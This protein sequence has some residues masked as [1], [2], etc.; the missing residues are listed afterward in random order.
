[1]LEGGGLK[2]GVPMKLFQFEFKSVEEI[3]PWGSGEERSLS[4][5]ALTDGF[6]RMPVG[7]QVLFRYRDEILAHLGIAE[8]DADY[9]IAAFARDI[10]GALDAG[11]APLSPRMEEL[12]LN[13]Q[14]LAVLEKAGKNEEF[15]DEDTTYTAWRWLGERSPWTS[16]LSEQPNFSFIR[17]KDNVHIRWDNRDK[18]IDGITVWS[19]DYGELIMPAGEFS[20]ECNSFKDRLLDAM[21][22][23]IEAIENGSA[24]PQIPVDIDSL[25]QQLVN[26]QTEFESYSSYKPDFAWD[27]VEQA[28]AIIAAKVGIPF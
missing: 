27:E 20:A 26:W 3:V 1:M 13:R 23:R 2:L 18:T 12:A 24:V 16:Y 6:F 14:K 8:S 9:F 22:N 25:R 5:F 28:I 15:E 11:L 17:L 19:A 21:G 4:L 7:E 10:L